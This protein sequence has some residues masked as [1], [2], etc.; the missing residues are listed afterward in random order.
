[1]KAKGLDIGALLIVQWHAVHPEIGWTLLG[2]SGGSMLLWWL[3]PAERRRVRFACGL[4]VVALLLWL[5]ARLP[6]APA[7]IAESALALEK[8]IGLHLAAVLLF[9]VILRRLRVPSIVIELTIGVGYIAIILDLLARVGVNL[10]GII[11]T[12]AVATAVIGFSLQD[13]LANLAGGLVMEFEQAIAQGDWIRTDQYFGQ[14]RSV[15]LRHTALETPDGDTILVPNSAITRSPVTILGRTAANA[16]GPIKHRRLLTFQLPYR[17]SPTTV[18]AAVEQ[19]MM[20]SPM[21]GVAEDPLPRCVILDFNPMYVQYGT[22]VWLMRPGLEYVDVSGVRTRIMF[23]LTRM[24]APLIPISHVVDL[25][26]NKPAQDSP[27]TGESDRVAALRGLEI[28]HSLNDEETQQL[29]SRMRK[30]S[31]AAGEVILRQGDEGDSLYILTRGRVRILLTNEAGLS[32]QVANLGPGDF[33][34]E[35]SL[36]TGEKR[37]ATAV[38]VEEADCY[39]LAKPD[40]QALLAER[41]ALAEEIS[42][43]LG[44]REM[45]LAAARD[46]LDAESVRQ[47]EMRRRGDLLRRIRSYF[48]VN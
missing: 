35:M 3:A 31:F 26:P 30:V 28:L 13:V 5:S 27:G 14:V 47:K 44:H 17:Y 34:G 24:G 7:W 32:E 12:S 10:T 36:L 46:K 43:V 29:A 23:A 21:E 40:V 39:C 25:R 38:A 1:M 18:T 4:W 6:S 19:A 2:L 8:V 45:G 37:N 22:L 15:R 42:D 33:F 11:A 20:A 41:P 9:R 16:I 48:A